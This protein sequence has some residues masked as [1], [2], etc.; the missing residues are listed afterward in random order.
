MKSKKAGRTYTVTLTEEHLYALTRGTELFER[1]T[2]GQFREI[3]DVVDPQFKLS[4]KDRDTAEQLLVLAR[5]YLMPELLTDYSYWSI[6]SKEISDDA[7][8]CY[9]FLQVVR[10]RLAWDNNPKGDWTV[11]FD[12][13]R[14]TS[15]LPLPQI[16][17]S[18]VSLTQS[19]SRSI[20]SDSGSKSGSKS[21]RGTRKASSPVGK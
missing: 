4:R 2:M 15:S 3:L 17:Q 5:R 19:G 1:I 18:E 14:Q 20:T 7:R 21:K 6:H 13:P 12:E 16:A 11:N 10:H 8:V 9:D